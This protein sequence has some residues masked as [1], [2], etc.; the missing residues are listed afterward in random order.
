MVFAVLEQGLNGVDNLMINRIISF[1]YS[2]NWSNPQRKEN[3][4]KVRW[5]FLYNIEFILV[6]IEVDEI[7]LVAK[8]CIEVFGYN[9]ICAKMVISDPTYF[10][11]GLRFGHFDRKFV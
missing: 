11:G 10:M 5:D 7:R 2:D 3:L 1:L 4:K 9:L 6:L 8:E